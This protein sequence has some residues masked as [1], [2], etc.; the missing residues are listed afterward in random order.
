MLGVC[1]KQRC[2]SF[3]LEFAFASQACELTSSLSRFSYIL[4]LRNWLWVADRRGCC[5]DMASPHLLPAS[6]SQKH[7]PQERLLCASRNLM[8]H[9]I[10]RWDS[11]PKSASTTCEASCSQCEWLG[12]LQVSKIAYIKACVYSALALAFCRRWHSFCILR[13]A[14]GGSRYKRAN[15]RALG[16][17]LSSN[18]SNSDTKLQNSSRSTRKRLIPVPLW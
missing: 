10:G 3:S 9:G 17:R 15:S 11:R 1:A 12:W 6:T 18:G 7:V 13:L 5:T 4:C 2:K 8:C 14:M 16:F